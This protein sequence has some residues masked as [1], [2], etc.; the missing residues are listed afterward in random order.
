MHLHIFFVILLGIVKGIAGFLC[1]DDAQC[2]CF[3]EQRTIYCGSVDTPVDIEFSD[4]INQDYDKL[5]VPN[6]FTCEQMIELRYRTGLYVFNSLHC[7]LANGNLPPQ[8]RNKNKKQEQVDSDMNIHESIHH[9]TESQIPS[10][11][12]LHEPLNHNADTITSKDYSS[13]DITFKVMNIL[14]VIVMSLLGVKL[15]YNMRPFVKLLPKPYAKFSSFVSYIVR[16]KTEIPDVSRHITVSFNSNEEIYDLNT[17]HEPNTRNKSSKLEASSASFIDGDN[18]QMPSLA[19][20]GACGGLDSKSPIERLS[21][22]VMSST[23]LTGKNSTKK[24][25][26]PFPPRNPKTSKLNVNDDFSLH[27]P[28]KR[29]SDEVVCEMG[30]ETVGKYH[31]TPLPV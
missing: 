7:P 9:K 17:E 16:R 1:G 31:S 22:P 19:E 11:V 5:L 24:P 21:P 23:K 29:R 4:N 14:I 30:M 27:T 13:F 15:H 18:P 6:S 12:K 3:Q 25:P 26:P 28:L 2:M 20:E 10:N 8:K